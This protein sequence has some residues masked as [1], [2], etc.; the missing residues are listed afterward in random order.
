MRGN[1]GNCAIFA[2][3]DNRRAAAA[4]GEALDLRGDTRPV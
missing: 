2:G 1:C 4:R 3:A